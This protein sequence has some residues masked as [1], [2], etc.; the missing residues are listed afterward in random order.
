MLLSGNLNKILVHRRVL[1]SMHHLVASWRHFYYAGWNRRV[2]K[3]KKA[4]T[5]VA[6]IFSSVVDMPQQ[7]QLIVAYAN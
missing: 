1:N 5:A 6:A 2:A 4:N 3:P 7:V